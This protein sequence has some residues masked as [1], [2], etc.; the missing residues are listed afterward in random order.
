VLEL[1]LLGLLVELDVELVLVP[2]A[3]LLDAAEDNEVN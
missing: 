1:V 3:V 2:A